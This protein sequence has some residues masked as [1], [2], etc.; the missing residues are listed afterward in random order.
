MNGNKIAVISVSGGGE[1]WPN[2]GCRNVCCQAL[3]RKGFS[4]VYEKMMCM[5]SNW[6]VPTNDHLA[7]RLIKAIPEKVDKILDHLLAGKIR[8]PKLRMG[9]LRKMI[10]RLEKA[11]APR[12]AQDFWL[13][14][15]CLVCGRCAK[16]CPVQNIKIED[17]QPV[18]NGRCVMC[19]RCIYSCPVQAIHSN[20]F[21]VI[22]AGYDLNALEK[23]MAGV[24]LLP[25]E[26]CC[27]G[28]LWKGVADYLTDQDGY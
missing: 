25:L 4:V 6:V 17:H 13:D 20:S 23:R 21:M 22:K 14:S 18:F 12:F 11:G 9:V 19:F 8:R 7:M 3:E 15:A 26:K 5:P 2:T 10:A 24:E 28:I 16:N 1:I 27:R